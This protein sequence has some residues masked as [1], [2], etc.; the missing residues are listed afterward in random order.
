MS[1]SAP[2]VMPISPR[3]A[4]AT[5]ASAPLIA[6]VVYRLDVGGLETVL[7]DIINHAPASRYRHAVICL[8]DCTDFRY[9]VRH[10]GVVFYALNKRAGKDLTT[11]LRL[12]RLLR[13]LKPALVHT[14]NI[15]ALDG[16]LLAALARVPAR[17]HA[18]HGRDIYDLDGSHR[19]YRRLRRLLS[20]LVDAFVP[21]SR[22]LERWLIDTVAIPGRKVTRICNGVDTEV[23]RPR[24]GQ[25]SAP[26]RRALG[27]DAVVIGTV[28]RMVPVKNQMLLVLA[29][30][31]LQSRRAAARPPLR[32]VILGDGPIRA[33][34]QAQLRDHGLEQCAWLPG[35]RADAAALV[36]D[37]DIFAL[38][39]LAEGIP[40]TVL[41]AMA[42]AVPVVATRV[43]G[44]P[45]I[46][47]DGVTGV[48][49]PSQDVAALA[50]ALERYIDAP[51]LRRQ[52]GRAGRARI[53]AEFSVRAT[54]E[55]YLALYDRLLARQQVPERRR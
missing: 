39:S 8:T 17:L 1:R 54:V 9:R 27:A 44:N 29:F 32:L 5:N 53:L 3:A 45:E 46:V 6:H 37:F 20:P 52:H 48:L 2:S 42:S 18:E 35:T 13:A 7:I 49:V 26:M 55:Q 34:A 50:G 30:I 14:C 21:V 11:Y 15:A 19:R 51:E 31:A 36:R 25:R 23:Y 10:P 28:G 43:G 16:V 40:L 33:Q 24:R 12:W 47:V 4:A 22:D 38:P 41:E